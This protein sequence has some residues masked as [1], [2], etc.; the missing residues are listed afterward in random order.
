MK[1]ITYI[2]SCFLLVVM[3]TACKKN[4]F[5][6]KEN[7]FIDGQASLKVN[8]FSALQA[9]PSYQIKIDGMRVSNNLNYPTPFPGGGL[10]T[11]GGSYADYLAVAPGSRK[12][13]ISISNV[14]ANTDSIAL[15]SATVNLEPN[16]VY[17][18][19]YADT[20][21]NTTTV[22]IEDDIRSPDSGFVKYRFINLMP[23]V[24]AG[25]DLYVGTTSN[26]TSTTDF[27]KVASSVQY[28]AAGDYFTVPINTGY[29][30]WCIRSA[31]ALATSA[32]IAVY[33]STST[34][35]N[36]RVFSITARGYNA[37]STPTTD[38]RIRAINFIFNR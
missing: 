26:Y 34:S 25:L 12:V 31:G 29:V 32:P 9:K 18:L 14:G 8:Y 10:N 36:Q 13:D 5:S 30:F 2:L 27:M 35:I 17:S 37:I 28:K 4:S 6:V 16:K 22:L 1:K 15:A 11:G 23:D 3:F 19:Y 33:T 20:A 21:A 7:I 38:G 24:P